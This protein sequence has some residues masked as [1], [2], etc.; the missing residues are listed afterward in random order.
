M[1]YAKVDKT[2]CINSVAG[3][4]RLVR[5]G[6][7]PNKETLI[8]IYTIYPISPTTECIQLELLINVFVSI[9]V[10]RVGQV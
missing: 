4:M 3:F 2:S 10:C 6:D 1:L 9:L 8:Y 5:Q 7:N